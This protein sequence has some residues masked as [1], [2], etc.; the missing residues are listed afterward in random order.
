M[1]HHS[2]SFC[3]F[4]EGLYVLLEPQKE[5]MRKK[6]RR[7]SVPA[8]L[9]H[10]VEHNVDTETSCPW[11]ISGP[12]LH[13]PTHIQQRYCYPKGRREYSDRVGGNLWTWYDT[14]RDGKPKENFE[15]RLFHVYFSAKRATNNNSGEATK[16]SAKIESLST[17]SISEEKYDECSVSTN[18]TNSEADDD[19]D[20][21]III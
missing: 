19:D 16:R 11:A 10:L 17:P 13:Q 5:N 15:F 21:F 8:H 9:A 4:A 20:D 1:S 7:V 18:G 12:Q 3:L 2:Q 6:G 14:D